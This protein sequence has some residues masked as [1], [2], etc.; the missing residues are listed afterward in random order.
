MINKE[1]YLDGNL[2]VVRK[3]V[4]RTLAIAET[5]YY[6]EKGDVTKKAKY[7]EIGGV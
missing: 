4:V 7:D 5:I 2:K 1:F 6:N 3:I